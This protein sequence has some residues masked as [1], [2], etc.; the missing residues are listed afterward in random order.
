MKNK[1]PNNEIISDIA[2][3]LNFERKGLIKILDMAIKGEL[4]ILVVAYKDRLARIGFELIENIIKTYSNG[5]IEII[6]TSEE[7]LNKD[8]I[9]IMNVYVA[10]VNGLRKYKTQMNDTIINSQKV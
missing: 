7:E 4:E 3:S 10:K 9:I 6:N 2:S 8:V 5:K 1:Y